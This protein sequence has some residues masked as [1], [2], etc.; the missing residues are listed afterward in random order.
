[1]FVALAGVTLTVG[2]ISGMGWP[3]WQDDGLSLCTATNSQHKPQI[4]ADGSGGAIVTWQ[5]YRDSGTSGYDIYAQRVG[6]GGV[7]LYL[8]LVMRK[9][10]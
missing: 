5:D 7:Y 6:E 10:S 9:Y 1:M 3:L 4:A 2:L 8:P